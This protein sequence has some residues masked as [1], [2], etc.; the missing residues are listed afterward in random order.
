MRCPI[1]ILSP[2]L[3]AGVEAKIPLPW[4]RG[5]G[6][7]EWLVEDGVEHSGVS[8][9]EILKAYGFEEYIFLIELSEK[10]CPDPKSLLASVL[11]MI[12]KVSG[13]IPHYLALCIAVQCQH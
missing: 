1:L 8:S 6:E 10:V 11:G 9:Q 4:E 5:E 7:L 13:S 12:D 2:V 3:P